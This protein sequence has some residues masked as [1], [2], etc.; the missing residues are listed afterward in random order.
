MK[1]NIFICFSLSILFE[2]VLTQASKN[3]FSSLSTLFQNL[4]STNRSISDQDLEFTQCTCDLTPNVCDTYCC[5]DMDCPV[6]ILTFWI[7]DNNNVCL[8][9][10][11]NEKNAFTACLEKD[12]LFKFNQKRGMREYE[13]DE[14]IC[15]VIDNSNR[16]TLFYTPIKEMSNSQ[17]IEIFRSVTKTKSDKFLF[18]HN[19]NRTDYSY[20][21]YNNYNAGDSIFIYENIDTNIFS[22]S[23]FMLRK[24]DINGGCIK[25]I[26]V[27]FLNDFQETKCGFTIVTFL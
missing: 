2:I 20:S 24:Q 16:K 21:L 18:Y 8:D 12:I 9:K 15:V 5:C 27:T 13:E 4:N 14:F 3:Y 19:L 6:S 26:P 25:S 17:S 11:N 23:R 22:E 1:N 7:I 10:K